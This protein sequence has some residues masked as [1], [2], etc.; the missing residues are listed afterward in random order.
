MRPVVNSWTGHRR[1]RHWLD[2]AGGVV[3]WVGGIATIVSI[4]GIFLYLLW[5]V[6]PLFHGA[7][8][9]QDVSLVLEHDAPLSAS[10]TLVGLD[11]YQE[12]VFV[13][14]G[15]HVRFLQMPHG[16][17]LPEVGGLL[18]IPGIVQSSVLVGQKGNLLS[19]GTKDGLLY[20]VEVRFRPAFEGSIRTIVPTVK[21]HQSMRVIP[22]GK[23]L[24]LHAH[25]KKDEWQSIAALTTDGTLWLTSVEE[26]G[27]FSLSEALNISQQQLVVPEGTTVTRL[28]LD[29][30]GKRLVAGT[31]NGELVEWNLQAK[32][33]SGTRRVSVSQPDDPVTA[34]EYLI[35]ERTLIVGTGSGQVMT[36]A[37]QDFPEAGGGGIPFRKILSFQSH[38]SPVQAISWSQRDKGFLTA[39]RQGGIILHHAT[40]GQTVLEFNRTEQATA[41]LRFSPKADGAVWVGTDGQLRTLSIDNPHPEVTFRSLFFPVTYEGYE[42]PEH[43]W[44]SSSGSDEFEPKLG[45]IPLIF[46]TLK[47]TIYA[48]ILAI[49]L[50][51]MGAIYTAM[52]MH[53]HLRS[54]VK[55][56]IEIMAALPSVVLGFLAGLWFAPLLQEIFPALVAMMGLLPVVIG[57]VCLMWQGLPKPLRNLDRYGLDLVVL[58]IVIVL[59]VGGCLLS[60]AVIESV[61]FNGNYKLWLSNHLGLVYDQRNA[62]VISFAMG[63]AVIPIIFSISEDSLSN[64]PRHLLAGSLAL[65][66]TKWQTLIRL[67]II[68][69]SPGI[70]SALMIGF[71]RAVGETMIVLMA[72]GNTPILDWSMFNGFRTLSANIAVEMPEAPHGG[73]LYRVLFLS[74]LILFGFTFCINTVAEVVRQRL[75]KKY[76]QY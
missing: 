25:T 43:I 23:E 65:G 33:E 8:G 36:W 45:L 60:N 69:A 6:L 26:P 71:G 55:P 31:Q 34:L 41:A 59:T 66:A 21:L 52:F 5:E 9:R 10:T 68:S 49:P 42:K 58:L 38:P 51:V 76:S 27:E 70:F 61:L 28:V 11:E 35:G 7:D 2:Q 13:L 74:G 39:D 64:V 46:G 63:F 50:A 48:M 72:T 12:V 57:L 67:V 18:E 16:N 20:P 30:F 54:V 29:R 40:T 19:V 56:T 73:T 3:V 24:S 14:E 44:Q 62:I 22:E 53:P 17:P 4:L 47:G 1:F 37:P 32:S 15:N 75:R